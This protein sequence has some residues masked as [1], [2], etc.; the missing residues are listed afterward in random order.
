MIFDKTFTQAYTQKY[1]EIYPE[2]NAYIATFLVPL[3]DNL[4]S[5]ILQ[6]EYY[7]NPLLAG[8]L[9][10][11][12]LAYM[13][14]YYQKT[15]LYLQKLYKKHLQN[16]KIYPRA[17][18]FTHALHVMHVTNIMSE[19]QSI[20]LKYQLKKYP[21]TDTIVNTNISSHLGVL[22]NWLTWQYIGVLA[23]VV[24]WHNCFP[25]SPPSTRTQKR[26]CGKK[27]SSL[28][29]FWSTKKFFQPHPHFQ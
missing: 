12:S 6:G 29:F 24:S 26:L 20:N 9:N 10:T 28:L 22:K 8:S 21:C 14:E 3:Y 16:V 2:K 15:K 19:T 1:L 7:P 27:N 4:A 18:N 5:I 11:L 25:L 13:T 17:V 23:V